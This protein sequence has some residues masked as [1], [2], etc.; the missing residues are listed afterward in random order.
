MKSNS[1]LFI[2]FMCHFLFLGAGFARIAVF[3]KTDMFIAAILGFLLGSGILYIL[4]KLKFN[5]NLNDILKKNNVINILFRF[6]YVTFILFNIMILFVFLSSFLFSYFLPY[7]PAI[8]ACFPFLLLAWYLGSK[9]MKEIYH[10]A[11]GLFIVSLVIIFIKTLLLANE[12]D[13]RNILPIL[14]TDKMNIFKGSLLYAILSISPCFVLIDED[15]SFKESFKY[16]LIGNITNMIIIIT[17]TLILGDMVNVYSYPEYT[18]LRRIRFFRFIEN[19]ENFICIN[20]FFDLFIALSIFINK[21]KSGLKSKN[22]FITF[23]ISFL[24]LF[25]VYK[26]FAN[27]YYNTMILYNYYPWVLVVF[28]VILIVVIGILKIFYIK[29][30]TNWCAIF[31]LFF[32]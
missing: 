21:L 27:N 11:F 1:N 8:I 15:I 3:C 22:N 6:L 13:I 28:V 19:I 7:T 23:G 12:F 9:N 31:A 30:S 32:L 18:I 4:C 24:V 25:G 16:Y 29:N 5:K 20:W 2:Y 26:I 14:D 17:I 10:V